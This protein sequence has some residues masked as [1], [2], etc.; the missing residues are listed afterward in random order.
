MLLID[1]WDGVHSDAIETIY[2][3]HQ[4]YQHLS[5]NSLVKLGFLICE[6]YV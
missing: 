6:I 3:C 5:G 2:G 4:L 1:G